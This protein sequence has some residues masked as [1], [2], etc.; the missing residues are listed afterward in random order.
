MDNKRELEKL[1]ACLREGSRVRTISPKI[2]AGLTPGVRHRAMTDIT[3]PPF[4]RLIKPREPRTYAGG[5]KGSRRRLQ[6]YLDEINQSRELMPEQ[7]LT[8]WDFIVWAGTYLKK[9]AM[10]DW[11]K[12]K[13]QHDHAWVTY[14]NYLK[15]LKKNL[16]P[17]E[18][19]DERN[20]IA[21]NAAEPNANDTITSWYDKLSELYCFRPAMH[22]GIGKT[23]IQDR[24]R[25]RLP[26]HVLMELQ[27]WDPTQVAQQPVHEI[28]AQLNAIID[29]EPFRSR[30]DNKKDRQPKTGTIEKSTTLTLYYDKPDSTTEGFCYQPSGRGRDFRRGGSQ[31][32]G[33]CDQG[34]NP[35]YLPVA[36][37]TSTTSV[38]NSVGPPH[39][40]EDFVPKGEIDARKS[41]GLCIKCGVAGHWTNKC[42][43]G[44]STAA[45]AGVNASK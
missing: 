15:V 18:D 1:N 14:N 7:F 19:T 8:E 12:Q 9:T 11:R 45:T 25:A 39:K 5:P 23:L 4:R 43:N 41:A 2:E 22:K 40:K 32:G 31:R 30:S 36:E 44:W 21:F 24:W 38:Q 29:S 34:R 10:N 26:H 17:G 20:I 33:G 27:C 42:K 6:E 35:N 16:S 28:S 13:E 37:K 3:P